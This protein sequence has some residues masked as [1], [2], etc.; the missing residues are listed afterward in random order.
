MLTNTPRPALVLGLAGLIPF[1]LGAAG[2]W[3]LPLPANV[4]ALQVQVL[5]AATILSFLGAVHW[6]LALANHGGA[7]ST[8]DNPAP[9]M[10]W[11]RLGWSVVPPLVAWVALALTAVPGLITFIIAFAG[12]W[13]GDRAAI[14]EGHA[15]GW[16]LGMRSLLTVLV[17]AA[18]ALSLIRVLL[19]FGDP[20]PLPASPG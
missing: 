18:L 12:M 11:K 9:A 6:G 17:I 1:Y 7:T 19:G 14:R 3:L 15:P 5:Y 20:H 2:V 8:P 13:L 16:Y 4:Y 10:T